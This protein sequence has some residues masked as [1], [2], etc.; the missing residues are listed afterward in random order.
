MSTHRIRRLPRRAAPPA[1]KQRSL[2]PV[3]I[4]KLTK[5]R[6][7][8]T[9]ITAPSKPSIST[10]NVQ[11]PSLRNHKKLSRAVSD[12]SNTNANRRQTSSYHTKSRIPPPNVIIR[13]RSSHTRNVLKKSGHFRHDSR[14]PVSAHRLHLPSKESSLEKSKKVNFFFEILPFRRL[15]NAI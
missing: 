2:T 11:L 4:P 8:P 7:T 6:D 1:K 3:T 12:S 15:F 13:S 5:P 9:K 10:K 14:S